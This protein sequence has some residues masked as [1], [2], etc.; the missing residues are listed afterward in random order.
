MR[1][2][3]AGSTLRW[4]VLVG[5]PLWAVWRPVKVDGVDFCW[6]VFVF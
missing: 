6:F 5:L 3:L 1:V 4:V 2:D